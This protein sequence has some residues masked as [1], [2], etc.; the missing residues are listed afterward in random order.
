MASPILSHTISL[1]GR[2]DL[3]IYARTANIN[4]FLKNALEPDVA[5]APQFRTAMMPARTRRRYPGD[6]RAISVDGSANEYVYDP[7]ARRG[8]SLPGKNFALKKVGD[9]DD[10]VGRRQFTFKGR[11]QD[12][13]AFLRAESKFDMRLYS[14]GQKSTVVPNSTTPAP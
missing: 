14:P 8:G 5:Q 12:L 13:L 9:P 1:P 3:V 11:Y 4:W 2:D 6:T 10:A 7:G